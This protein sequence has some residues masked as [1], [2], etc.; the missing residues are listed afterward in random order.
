MRYAPRAVGARPRRAFVAAPDTDGDAAHAA[1]SP[2]S[3]DAVRV[4]MPF[5]ARAVVTRRLTHAC[6]PA[7]TPAPAVRAAI[8]RQSRP[9][10]PR[11][12][13]MPAESRRFFT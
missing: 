13:L 1:L 10:L 2:R 8:T 4:A 6:L 3:V 7:A 11:L 9:R 12:L 5:A